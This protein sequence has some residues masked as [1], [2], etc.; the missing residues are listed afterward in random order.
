MPMPWSLTCNIAW[1]PSRFT[2][3]AMAALAG[4]YFTALMTRLTMTCST[5]L[6]SALI[7]AGA[8]S[9]AI[10]CCSSRPAAHRLDSDN[11]T[12]S[13]RFTGNRSSTILPVI[14]RPTSSR[15]SISRARWLTWRAS[16]CC[17]LR[18]VSSWVPRLS[19]IC[20]ALLIA[21]SGLGSSCPSIARNSSFLRLAS[22]DTA[23]AWRSRSRCS[24]VAC[25]AGAGPGVHGARAGPRRRG[26]SLANAMN[27]RNAGLGNCG[28]F[29]AS[30]AFCRGA[31]LQDRNGNT[32]GDKCRREGAQSQRQARARAEQE[33]GVFER[34]GESGARQTHADT[35]LTDFRARKGAIG[36]LAVERGIGSPS[37]APVAC[38]L[39]QT[40]RDRGADQFRMPARAR[41]DIAAVVEH[42]YHSVG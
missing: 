24:A 33:V 25:S 2:L 22:L 10:S 11:C 13:A 27:F 14:T 37:L 16:T 23:R 17:A 32:S 9:V 7:H 40:R 30:D 8:R 15:S 19:R 36:A 31:Q 29:P 1:S 12:A 21:A 5:R 34:P 26:E 35:P 20:T 39:A 4:V 28:Y 42:R 3:M 38:Q 18:A 6:R 41:H